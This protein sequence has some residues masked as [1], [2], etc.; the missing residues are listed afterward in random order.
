MQP[1]RTRTEVETL[2]DLLGDFAA[3]GWG[4]ELAGEAFD[5]VAARYRALTASYVAAATAVEEAVRQGRALPDL[6]RTLLFFAHRR[7]FENLFTNAG[8]PRRAGDPGGSAVYY[9]GPKGDRRHP[10]FTGTPAG[11]LDDALRSAFVRLQDRRGQGRAS[12]DDA[13]NDAVRFYADLSHIHP[14]YDGNGRTGRFV[15][16]VYLHLHGWLVEWG[17]VEEKDKEF[18]RRINNVNEKKTASTDYDALLLRF[19]RE[20][21][22]RTDGLA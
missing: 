8:Q 16:S 13:R 9:G 10:R 12:L 21:V 4:P 19:W 1:S 20:R 11:R 7:L 6:C 15:V 18:I 14:F 5:T 17:R 22:V 3:E 2:A